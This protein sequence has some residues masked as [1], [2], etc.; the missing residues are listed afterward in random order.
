MFTWVN[1]GGGVP[2]TAL[3]KMAP[4]VK[5]KDPPTVRTSVSGTVVEKFVPTA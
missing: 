3:P 5:V 2:Y 1:I 4:L